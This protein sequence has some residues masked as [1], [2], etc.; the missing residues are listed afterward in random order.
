MYNYFEV[1]SMLNQK[2]IERSIKTEFD[3]FCEERKFNKNLIESRY[4]STDNRRNKEK[5]R[6]IHV[7]VNKTEIA[8]KTQEFEK[9]RLRTL[10]SLPISIVNLADIRTN[11]NIAILN[12]EEKTSLTLIADGQIYKID[13]IEDGMREIFDKINIKENSYAKVYEICKNT[14]LYTTEGQNLQMDENEY[15]AEI[16][17]TLYNIVTKTKELIFSENLNIGKLYISGSGTVINNID[18]YF[19]ENFKEIK[20]EILKPYFVRTEAVR[21]NIKDYIEV[22]SA[23]ALA[24]Q[25]LGEGIKSINLQKKFILDNVE[26]PGFLSDFSNKTKNNFNIPISL[27]KEKGFDNIEKIMIHFAILILLLIVIYSIST[28]IIQ[29]QIKDKNEEVSKINT[30]INNEVSI[31]ENDISKINTRATEY[32]NLNKN[33]DAINEKTIEKYRTKNAIPNFLNRIMS[34]IPKNLQLTSIEITSGK[35]AIIKAQS[36][37]YEQLGMFKAQIIV[38]NIL[39]SVTSDI[40][41]KQSDLVKVTI[42]GDLP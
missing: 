14:M 38:D 16:M 24:L 41:V 37:N 35:H 22:N 39:L 5:I 30:S 13:I 4:F 15:L 20:C 36:S 12:M 21:L 28:N 33:L 3:F 32:S 6:A 2:D 34:A 40:S 42:E 9:Y 7:S 27:K 29:K 31:V 25:G 26:L 17:L 1:F 10:T 11:E 23:I 18:L 8:R 19:Q